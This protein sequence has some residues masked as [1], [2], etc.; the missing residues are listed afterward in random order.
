M[1]NYNLNEES[2]DKRSNAS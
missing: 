2:P 1:M